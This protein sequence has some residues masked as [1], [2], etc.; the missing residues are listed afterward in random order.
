MLHDHH[1]TCIIIVQNDL[2]THFPIQNMSTR[3]VLKIMIDACRYTC[4]PEG[5]YVHLIPNAVA[6]SWEHVDGLIRTG[7]F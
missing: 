6:L 2:L 4:Q 3:A 7:L 5:R 1:D